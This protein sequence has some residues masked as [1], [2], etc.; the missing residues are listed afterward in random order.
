MIKI[1][2]CPRGNQSLSN[3]KLDLVD[4]GWLIL[5]VKVSC[6]TRDY[7]IRCVDKCTYFSL[8][9]EKQ[10]QIFLNITEAEYER[11]FNPS[12]TDSRSFVFSH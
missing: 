3:F 4:N 2:R 9:I 11:K 7:I 6:L 5:S 12:A 1:F 8:E 10:R